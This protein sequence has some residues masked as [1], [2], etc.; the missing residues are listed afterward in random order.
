MH[1][2]GE[3]TQSDEAWVDSKRH[4][5]EKTCRKII[6]HVLEIAILVAMNTH[7]YEFNGQIYR[8]A[9]GGPIGMRFTACLAAVIMKL[10]DTAWVELMSREGFDIKMYARYVDDSR[11]MVRPLREGW[12]WVNGGFKYREE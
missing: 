6:G 4:I 3:K 8:Q 9:S 10:W 12:R 2:G 11:N 5:P 7:L 1:S